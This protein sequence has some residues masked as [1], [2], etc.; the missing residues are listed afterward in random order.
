MQIRLSA[1]DL[2]RVRFTVSPLWETVTSMRALQLGTRLHRPWITEATSRILASRDPAKQDHLKLLTTLIRPTGFIADSLTPTPLRQ[3]TF[4]A[5]LAAVAAV[6]PELWVRDL[7]YLMAVERDESRL[8]TISD[9]CDDPTAGA[10]RLV[11]ALRWYWETALEPFWPRLRSMLLADLDYRL[12][13]LA[14][15]GI[16]QVFDT[17]HPSVRRTRDGLEVTANCD[18]SH[19][20]APGNGLILVPSAFVWPRTLVLDVEPFVPT[21]TYAPRGVGRLW[22][23]SR[24]VKDSPVAKLLGHTRATILAQLDLPMTTTQLAC[25]LELAA[26]T[27]NGHLKVLEASGLTDTIRA[28]REVFYRRAGLG[29]DLLA[30]A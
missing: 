25:A 13:L 30:R 19:H 6:P 23:N 18:G 9:F 4:E 8:E 21:L 17:L 26:G 22:E 10:T 11:D 24:Q 7:S 12:A 14:E 2:T 15:H 3:D 20:A 28:G 29:E 27:V 1:E 5:G 16:H